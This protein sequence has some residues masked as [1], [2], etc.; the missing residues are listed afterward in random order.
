MRGLDRDRAGRAKL[1]SISKSF[2]KRG[3]VGLGLRMC[4]FDVAAVGTAHTI[5]IV[6]VSVL[7]S[8][9]N[10]LVAVLVDTTTE[11]GV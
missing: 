6:D 1:G 10:T 3:D 7:G 8:H 11:S 4:G 5:V 9:T 2:D